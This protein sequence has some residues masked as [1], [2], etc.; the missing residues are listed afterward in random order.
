MKMKAF[1]MGLLSLF[2]SFAENANAQILWQNEDIK[3]ET[4]TKEKDILIKFSPF[5]G[6]HIL[7]DNA[8]DV[9]TPTTF[10]W[11]TPAKR[12]HETTPQK[13]LY[14]DILGQ[15]GY[16]KEAY[17][18]FK[19]QDSI[20]ARVKIDWTICLEE[21][22]PQS[23]TLEIKQNENEDEFEKAYKTFSE[24]LSEKLAVHIRNEHLV[25]S[26]PQEVQKEDKVSFIPREKGITSPLSTQTI[27]EKNNRLYLVIESEYEAPLLQSGLLIINGKAYQIETPSQP[28]EEN[29]LILFILSFLG[30][31]LLN[32]MPCVFPILSIK[33][34]S[35]VHTGIHRR[36]GLKYMAGVLTCFAS[37]A[38]ILY[39]LRQSG[40][41]LGWGFQLQSPMFVSF[42]LLI[43]VIILLFML[44]LV[45]IKG[46]LQALFSRI[47]SANAF[48]TGLFAVLIA[49]PCSG[50][51]LGATVG[52]ALLRSKEACFAIFLSMGLGY[53]LPFTL[54]EFFPKT[55]RKILP[56]PGKWMNTFKKILAIPIF[57]TCLWLGWLLIH[58]MFEKKSPKDTLWQPYNF[59]QIENLRR[60]KKPIFI[61]FTA[62]WCLTCLL[63]EKAVL[64]KEAFKQIAKACHIAL[65]KADWTTQNNKITK[66]LESYNRAS[67]PLYVYY[68]AKGEEKILPQIL[69]NET[70]K[71]YLDDCTR[72]S[73]P[74]D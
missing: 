21:C 55:M 57:L 36:E 8:G 7:W 71:E 54:L 16:E 72:F 10:E 28:L 13:F 6:G 19:L 18:L 12:L 26:L 23:T 61:D 3:I 14:E 66:A 50:P 52:Y 38:G 60:L 68:S 27:M 67:V 47:N 43:F 62:K 70:L 48:L 4:F 40:A 44:N 9:G 35:I 20:N 37:M 58:L 45:K 46:R 49:S 2:L 29:W 42:M 63:N 34:L 11:N 32:F 39:F 53:A 56:T 1:W 31:M 74:S 59:E 41:A 33:A 22:I 24:N 65:F 30:G 17:Y 73:L 51:L 64:S 69:T 25:M 15:Y 5:N